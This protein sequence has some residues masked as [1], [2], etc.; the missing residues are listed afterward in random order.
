LRAPF[1]GRPLRAAARG[2]AHRT[3]DTVVENVQTGTMHLD[4]RELELGASSLVA[5]IASRIRP[6]KVIARRR[7]N[8]ERLAAQVGDLAPV[9]GAPLAPG[10][11][12]LFLPVRVADKPALLARLHA[13]GI[14]AVDFW[15]TGDPACDLAEFP[16]VAR[17]R[18]EILE[19]P[20]HQSLDD[21]S[22]DFVAAAFREEL[23][24]P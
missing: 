3:V 22:I 8:F 20:C 4:P 5:H 24:G 7:R 16:E 14:D 1:V 12:P 23:R 2:L 11:C 6:E 15:S 21:E 17:L 13:R 18:R 10:V 9:V 19:L